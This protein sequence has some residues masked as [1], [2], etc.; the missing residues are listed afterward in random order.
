MRKKIIKIYKRIRYL[1]SINWIKTIYF[2]FRLLPYK[3]ARKIPFF[4]YKRVK[5][6]FENGKVIINSNVYRGMIKIGYSLELF[7]INM[8]P[9]EFSIKGTI[10][11][12]GGFI[13][14]CG[15]KIIICKDA[16]LDIGENSYIG[17]NSKII[18]TNKVFMGAYTRI[19]YETQI[20]DSNFHYLLDIEKKIVS[21]IK[22]CVEINDYCW[23]GNRS[24]IMKGTKT[25]EH[26]IITS[27]SL[28]NKDY[29][30][31]VPPCSIIGGIPAKLIKTGFIRFYGDKEIALTSYFE[32]NNSDYHYDI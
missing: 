13:V 31:I 15:S 9:V 26:C 14:G 11:I 3:Q 28:L 21:N 17:S 24:S 32:K 19:S 25:P 4:I 16:I 8:N 22:G 1:I 6:H 10:N 18:V 23:I 29:K 20:M 12:N 5:F 2:N 7:K 30:A 27:N